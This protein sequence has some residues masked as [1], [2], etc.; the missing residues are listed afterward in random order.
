M[1]V[2]LVI[3][4]CATLEPADL[5]GLVCWCPFGIPDVQYEGWTLMKGTRSVLIKKVDEKPKQVSCSFFPSRSR[6]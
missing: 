2:G 6:C 4:H 3:N 1:M 5:E